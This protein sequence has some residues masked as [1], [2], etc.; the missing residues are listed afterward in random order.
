[1]MFKRKKIILISMLVLLICCI[2]AVNAADVDGVNDIG[3]DIVIDEVT[4]V[5]DEVEI[6]SVDDEIIDEEINNIEIDDSGDDIIEKN[7]ENEPKE[8][9]IGY[10]SDSTVEE[11]SRVASPYYIVNSSNYR[12]YFNPFTGEVLYNRDLE[13][14]GTFSNLYYN[15]VPFKYF[16]I[17]KNISLKFTNAAF[18]NVGFKLLYP[19]LT[20][21]NA[22]FTGNQ[23]ALNEESIYIAN[24]NI[25][26]KNVSINVTTAI[27]KD[28]YAINI[29][30]ANNT[31]LQ[32]ST[33]TY[34]APVANPD[35]YNYV[36]RVVN[37]ERVQILRN[38]ITAFLPLKAVNYE[39]PFPSIYTDCVAVIAVQSSNR[40]NLTNN[41]IRV[42]VSSSDNSLYPTLD[43]VIMVDSNN[44][45]IYYNDIVVFD[46]ITGLNV[47]NYLYAVDIYECNNLDIYYN[48]I[49]IN[50]N[51]GIVVTNGSGAA[52]PIQLTGPY[53]HIRISSNNLTSANNGPNCGIYS[54]NYYGATNYLTINKNKIIITGKAGPNPYSLVSGIE[55]QDTY[56]VIT[57]NQIHVNNIAG[58]DESNYAFG[59]S[60]AQY[61]ANN[62]YF[63]IYKN[64]VIVDNATYAVYLLSA[65]D[66]TKVQKNGLTTTNF[67]GDNAVNILSGSYIISGNYAATPFTNFAISSRDLDSKEFISGLKNNNLLTCSVDNIVDGLSNDILSSNELVIYVGPNENDGDG[68]LENPYKDFQLASEASSGYDSVTINI[69]NGTYILNSL[70]SFDN[71]NVDFVGLGDVTIYYLAP[72]GFNPD[73]FGPW[74]EENKCQVAL[75]LTGPSAH[76]KF[77]NITFD[78]SNATYEDEHGVYPID[79]T[80]LDFDKLEQCYFLFPFIGSDAEFSNCSFIKLNSNL[81]PQLWDFYAQYRVFNDCN[82]STFDSTTNLYKG[83]GQEHVIFNYCNLYVGNIIDFDQNPDTTLNYVWFGQNEKILY[84]PVTL[85]NYAVFSISENYLGDNQYEIIGKLAWNDTT[86]DGIE[87]LGVKTVTL[88]TETG[89]LENHTVFLE[90]G[91]FKV[92]YTSN[93]IVNTVTAT[94]DNEVVPINFKNVDISVVANPIDYGQEQG[95]SINFAPEITGNVTINVN[96]ANYTLEL[97][98]STSTTN[99]IIPDALVPE[100]YLISVSINDAINHIYGFGSANMTVSKIS[101]YTFEP[102]SPAENPKVSDNLTISVDLPSN[103][104]GTVTV[105]VNN[106]PFSKEASANTELTVNGLVAGVNNITVV[107]SGN[108]IYTNKSK[109]FT[110]TAEKVPID[111]KNNTIDV[112]VPSGTTSPNISINLPEDAT[113]NLTVTV[114]GKNYTKALVNG[115]AT[116]NIADLASGTYKATVTYSGDDNY[117]SITSNTTFTIDSIKTTI[118]VAQ[119]STTYKVAKNL[120]ITLKDIDGK[121][122]SGQ[123]ITVKVGTISKTLTTN[124]KGQVSLN[125]ASLVPK[126]Y[127]ASISFAGDKVYAKS[128]ASAKVVVAKA[129]SKITAKKKTFKAK[130]KVKKYAIT[131]KA[132]KKAIKKV[133]IILKVKGKTYKAK[134]NAKGKAIFKIKKLTKKGKFNAAI[135]F[136]GNKYY[137]ATSK[138]VKLTIKK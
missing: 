137:K 113:G 123:K 24:N 91:T 105:Y 15:N 28:F 1:M 65:N 119:I 7:F 30:D 29:I 93:S 131:L 31:V 9:E 84:M 67:T 70:I 102:S 3:D 56:G 76:A 39:Q 87:R 20:I 41:K 115:K 62:H 117:D 50:S 82:F 2:S 4:D 38:N 112:N 129:K 6:D 109:E 134:T 10:A 90:N 14:Q 23:S 107:Y 25:S 75:W 17:N 121:V 78:Y 130:V 118:S 125:I 66:T 97:T 98:E 127:K 44:S 128:S 63:Y 22:T 47:A 133:K 104:N 58:Y 48:N 73:D 122:L 51:G 86:D 53:N 68:T 138:K 11:N 18:N 79:S 110:I 8:I 80:D 74:N 52:Y 21:E 94:L 27:N 114:D 126:T 26:I 89:T 40:L 5:V 16:V 124:A 61:T 43:T 37:S 54:Q 136:A 46:P 60:Y 64:N 69:L 72:E 85:N 106:N 34:N 111:V 120:V 99:Y 132:G 96:N 81:I 92:K 32:D 57:N 100:K 88:S 116:V 19:G 71:N 35:K 95:I 77:E 103:V 135:K 42:N 36:V 12:S 108:E 13:F 55:T 101:D 83:M 33:I 59:I 49:S 45:D